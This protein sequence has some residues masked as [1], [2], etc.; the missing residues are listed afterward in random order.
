M[1]S[2]TPTGIE[3][4]P[5]SS[6]RTALGLAA[7]SG[8]A[9]A[10]LSGPAAPTAHA[11]PSV[12]MA[13]ILPAS[14]SALSGSLDLSTTPAWH[15][16]RRVC[17]APVK[18][19]VN[20]INKV[21]YARWI[22]QQLAW[23]K[24]DDSTADRLISKHLSW[25][26]ITTS[27]LV[28]STKDMSWKGAKA[29]SVSRTIRQLYT[30]RY[31]YESMVDTMADHLYVS[32]AGKA[33]GWVAWYDWAVLRRS[34]LGKFSTLLKRA[35]THPAMLVNLDN[36]DNSADNP[37]ENLGRELLELHTVGVGNYT[38][39]DVRNSA[40]LLTGHG[41]SWDTY[42]YE[43][44]PQEHYV[45]RVTV[46]GFSHAN[47]KRSDGPAVLNDYLDYLARHPA[48]ARHVCRRLAVRYV[49]DSPSDALIDKLA[50]VYLAKNTSLTEVMRALLTSDEFKAS[51]GSKWRRP[52]ESIATMI[53][54]AKP[55]SS[56]KPASKQTGN[57]WQ[58]LGTVQWLLSLGAHEPRMWGVVDG[59][60]D[61]AVDWMTSQD[62]LAHWNSAYARVNWTD[63]EIPVQSWAKALG[64]TK[65][66][67]VTAA[68]TRI[69]WYVTGYNWKAEHIARVATRLRGSGGRKLTADQLRDNLPLA[70][71]L[72]FCSP[73]FMLR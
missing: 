43:Y 4:G 9:V 44:H 25:A 51:V 40:L 50:A 59:Y 46:M 39:T 45:G 24:I 13:P 52:Q 19:I 6:R 56:L 31:L 26:T 21:G 64:I 33:G 20:Q 38:Q 18:S 11:A 53:K 67:D 47:S 36:Q 54:V 22:D 15:L 48:T 41:I 63:P 69:A 60:P 2:P 65:G 34:A 62:L 28:K 58:I 68:A 35:I 23:K 17:P 5:V 42:R 70:V 29:L 8:L 12:P 66:M 61:Q 73:Y 3:P 49:C 32:A 72:V 10:G 27:A 55:S 57:L 1:S 37:N 16:A 7:A 71:H 14:I 30:R